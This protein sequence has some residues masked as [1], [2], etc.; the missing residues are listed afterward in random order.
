M[1]DRIHRKGEYRVHD[2]HTGVA[3]HGI[4]NT[5]NILRHDTCH[6]VEGITGTIRDFPK[7]YGIIEKSTIQTVRGRASQIEQVGIPLARPRHLFGIFDIQIEITCL[8]SLQ[9]RS[10]RTGDAGYPYT[11]RVASRFAR[12]YEVGISP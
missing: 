9:V 5:G 8:R 3:E 10:P 12:S 11:G 6:I 2:H 7:G 1:T 4:T